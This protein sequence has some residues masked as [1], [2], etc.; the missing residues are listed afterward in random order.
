MGDVVVRNMD[1]HKSQSQ[2][3]YKHEI[4]TTITK[5]RNMPVKEGS[6]DTGGGKL[7][8]VEKLV[9]AHCVFATQLRITL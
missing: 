8:L 6:G 2:Q 1:I 7:M 5:K 3:C 4:Q 9:L